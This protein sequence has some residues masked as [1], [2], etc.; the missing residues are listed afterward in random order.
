LVD[1][2]DFIHESEVARIY[3]NSLLELQF[4]D[5]SFHGPTVS[6]NN[7]L[8][9]PVWHTTQ[10]MMTILRRQGNES[11]S[12]IQKA[13]NWLLSAHDKNERRWRAFSHFEVYFTSYAIISMCALKTKDRSTFDSAVDWLIEF[14][15]VNPFFFQMRSGP[16]SD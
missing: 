3:Y 2:L 6:A 9:N 8:T 12:K 4:D 1:Y 13:V 14:S 16:T 11:D 5:G 7:E 15:V 10:A